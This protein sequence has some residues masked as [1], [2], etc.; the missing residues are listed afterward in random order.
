[1]DSGFVGR[2]FTSIE[3]S[4]IGAFVMSLFYRFLLSDER[5]HGAAFATYLSNYLLY[6]TD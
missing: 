5:L 6:E 4:I 3:S 2:Y 1:M